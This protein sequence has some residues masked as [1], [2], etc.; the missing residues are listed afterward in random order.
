VYG[1]MGFKEPHISA[2]I[3]QWEGIA[4]GVILGAY[5]DLPAVDILNAVCRSI[6]ASCYLS[7]AAT[8][9]FDVGIGILT[10]LFWWLVQ[11][12]FVCLVVCFSAYPG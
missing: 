9:S 3:S 7:T 8:V 4:L 10:H 12:M 11:R 6:E 1:L 2:C 5:R